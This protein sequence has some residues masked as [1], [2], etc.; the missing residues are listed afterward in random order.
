MFES[1]ITMLIPTL[2]PIIPKN[3]RKHI[4]TSLLFINDEQNKCIFNIFYNLYNNCDKI[5]PFNNVLHINTLINKTINNIFLKLFY[6]LQFWS[7]TFWF[8]L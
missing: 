8:Y 3:I 7:Y 4:V 6:D 2:H 5:Q 1:N